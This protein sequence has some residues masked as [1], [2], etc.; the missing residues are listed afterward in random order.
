MHHG[1]FPRSRNCLPPLRLYRLLPI[2]KKR[3][4]N[5]P[6]PPTASPQ[7]SP[8]IPRHRDTPPSRSGQ[9]P[10]RCS[11]R[12]PPQPRLLEL[13]EGAR[14]EHGDEADLGGAPARAPGGRS[15]VG[16]RVELELGP[17]SADVAT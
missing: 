14:V 13:T 16:R 17:G 12:P 3:K 2:Q 1:S 10:P 8:T 5:K 7:P 6:S 4:R 9:G 11:R 15:V